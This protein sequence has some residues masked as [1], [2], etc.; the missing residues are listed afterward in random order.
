[1]PNVIFVL[2]YLKN[3]NIKYLWQIKK[4]KIINV[5]SSNTIFRFDKSKVLNINI[6]AIVNRLPFDVYVLCN[7]QI[8][9]WKSL[10]VL[11]FDYVP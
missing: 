7:S 9:L 1:M 10:Q 11:I 8:G 2:L 4:N 3:Y 5:N 6:F